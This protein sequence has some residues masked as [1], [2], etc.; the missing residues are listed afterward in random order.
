MV[1]I[2]G[3]IT[4]KKL[5]ARPLVLVDSDG[6]DDIICLDDVPADASEFNQKENKNPSS[7]GEEPTVRKRNTKKNRNEKARKAAKDK[8][9]GSS[10]APSTMGVTVTQMIHPSYELVNPA[11]DVRELFVRFTDEFFYGALGM[12]TVEWSKRMTT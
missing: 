8:P 10:S 2:G 6:D 5:D 11:P 7:R 12:C 4:R 9:C 1:I 3:I